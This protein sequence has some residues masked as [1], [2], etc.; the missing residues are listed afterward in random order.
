[1]TLV[2]IV[3]GMTL[4]VFF[5][6]AFAGLLKKF[7]ISPPA[8]PD[9]ESLKPVDLHFRCGVCGT[10]VTMTMASDLEEIDAPRHCR[11]DM[12]LATSN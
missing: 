12:I 11:E 7:W 10:E 9:R 2:S 6:V 8:E 1:V 4:G 3:I 5:Y